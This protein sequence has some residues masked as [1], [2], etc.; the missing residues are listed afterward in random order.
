MEAANGN[1]TMLTSAG[2]VLENVIDTC[3]DTI[4]DLY[5]V[6]S[7]PEKC[8]RPFI[9]SLAIEGNN[10]TEIIIPALFDGGAMV[11]DMW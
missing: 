5:T 2:S 7:E 4:Y 3:N 6:G 10:R 8:E 11:G 9:H 1:E